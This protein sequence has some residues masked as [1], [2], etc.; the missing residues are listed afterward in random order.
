M[1]AKVRERLAVSKQAAKRFDGERF[2]L[3]KLNELEVRKQYQIEVTNRSEALENLNDDKD[4]N[5]ACE[6]I[7]EYIKTSAKGNLGL[8]ESKQHKPWFDEECLG[9]LDQMKR[10]K[11][12]GIHDPSQSNVDNL[13][14]VRCDA[15][16][17]FRSKKKTYLKAKIEE[18]KTNSKIKNIR[19]LYKDIN[20]LR[21]V[22]SQELI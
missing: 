16:R 5:R 18:L 10:A 2:N 1:V 4:I 21:R 14:N 19:D 17:H 8:Q 20:D 11:M 12:Q 3:R 13:N 7:K 6:N 22:T 9:F 15:S